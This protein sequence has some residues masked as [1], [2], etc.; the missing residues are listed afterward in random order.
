MNRE[1]RNCE[2]PLDTE[3]IHSTADGFCSKSCQ[4]LF[5]KKYP[6]WLKRAE[7]F[8]WFDDLATWLRPVK[9]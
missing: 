8:G 4:E 6:G 7:R 1:C 9:R 3:D 5:R 2:K